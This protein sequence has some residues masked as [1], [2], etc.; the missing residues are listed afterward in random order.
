MKTL[1]LCLLLAASCG[2]EPPATQHVL[3]VSVHYAG[4]RPYGELE[5]SRA[6][7]GFDYLYWHPITWDGLEV[8]LHD[9][10]PCLAD[11]ELIH[12]LA[13]RLRERY[14]G[15]ADWKHTDERYFPISWGRRSVETTVALWYA[16]RFC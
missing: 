6:L 2:K 1:A 12:Q 9:T 5:V 10:P 7:L 3:G 13:H 4:V 8:R 16:R 11:S 14:E 15:G